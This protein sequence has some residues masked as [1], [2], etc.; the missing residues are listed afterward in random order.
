V[1]VLVTL[2]AHA[3]GMVVVLVLSVSLFVS[4]VCLCEF[5]CVCCPCTVCIFVSVC[6]ELNFVID[7]PGQR[8]AILLGFA[9][10][11]EMFGTFTS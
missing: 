3:S 7:C 5:V 1:C 10:I 11:M 2:T 9:I 8:S 6:V 4:A